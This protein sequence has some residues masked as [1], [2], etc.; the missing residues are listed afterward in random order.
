[1][2][3]LWRYG[4]YCGLRGV[5]GIRISLL[6]LFNVSVNLGDFIIIQQPLFLHFTDIRVGVYFL[7][8]RLVVYDTVVEFIFL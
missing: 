4:A 8:L 5:V 1:M 2:V 7:Q 6:L 3:A